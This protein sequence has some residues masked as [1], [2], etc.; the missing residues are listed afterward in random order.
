MGYTRD[1]TRS[2][3]EA[4]P[5]RN[6]SGTPRR[7]FL[8]VT[9]S[10]VAVAL[11]GCTGGQ[12]GEQTETGGAT[13]EAT[14]EPTGTEMET[15]TSTTETETE[16]ET[17]TETETETETETGTEAETET[18]AGGGEPTV[19]EAELSE[20]AIDLSTSTAPAGLVR[21][22]T[23]NVG[24]L[25]HELV[26]VRSDLDPGELPTD[27][28]DDVDE[29]QI[30]VVDE[31]EDIEGGGQATLEVT[32]EAGNYVLICNLPAHYRLGMYTGFTVTE[33]G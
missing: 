13:P 6:Q 1:Q 16:T 3:G 21:F 28:N 10:A 4:A 33:S 27:E 30:D 12:G 20:Y 11:A 18:T 26:V 2:D 15:G 8:T 5:I 19:V 7:A 22:E 31:I 25:V 32:L 29:E 9:G 17:G 24:Q 14:P 23:R